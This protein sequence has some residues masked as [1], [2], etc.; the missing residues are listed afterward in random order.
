MYNINFE[1]KLNDEIITIIIKND[2]TISNFFRKIIRSIPKTTE[3]KLDK[4]GSFVILCIL[5]KKDHNTIILELEKKFGE[6]IN[7]ASERLNV[8]IKFLK[9]KKLI[10]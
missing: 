6:E 7:P 10:Y 4:Y 3:I 2:H 5:E 8:Y 1:Y 9:E